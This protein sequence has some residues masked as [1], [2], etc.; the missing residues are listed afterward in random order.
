VG[1]SAGT[2][3]LALALALVLPGSALVPVQAS[4]WWCETVPLPTVT[5]PG[6]LVV[7][8]GFED[9]SLW[10]WRVVR[11]GDAR[12]YVSNSR[13]SSGRCSGRLIVSS[14]ATAR[15][16]VQRAL[17][18]GTDEVWAMGWFR[19]DR[20]G[21]P[22]SNVPTFRFFDG[23]SRILDVYRQNGT[24]DLWIRTATGTGTWR[25]VQLDRKLELFRW[26]HVEVHVRA[27][28]GS[29]AISVRLDG[30]ELHRTSSAYLPTSRLT[31]AMIGA[32]HVRQEMDLSFDDIVITAR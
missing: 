19:V 30:A 4:A 28:W 12:A 31:I 15:A 23:S 8:D 3:F 29:S 11:D 10:R 5:R 24:G 25:Y 13:S 14:D 17:P 32:E 2:T 7:S 1:R 21:G 22:E 16:N 27:A 20:E 9:G 26:H 18:T 6:A